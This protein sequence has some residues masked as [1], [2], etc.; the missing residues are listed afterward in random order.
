MKHILKERAVK[1]EMYSTYTPQV[2]FIIG[3]VQWFYMLWLVKQNVVMSKQAPNESSSSLANF[4]QPW[5]DAFFGF[6]WK[7]YKISA[8]WYLTYSF[9][10]RV[11]AFTLNG[12]N[13]RGFQIN[14]S[15][16]QSFFI[17]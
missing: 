4:K 8:L 14:Q 17:S 16:N 5:Y 12:A 13:I 10:V 6:K 7:L 9:V 3:L 11:Q 2:F 1:R 15:I